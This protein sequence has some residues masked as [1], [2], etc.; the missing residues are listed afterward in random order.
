MNTLKFPFT[1]IVNPLN[2]CEEDDIC[3]GC[4]ASERGLALTGL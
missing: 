1:Q 3:S 2:K 4:S